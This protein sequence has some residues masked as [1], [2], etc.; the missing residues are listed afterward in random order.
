MAD[1]FQAASYALS[2]E[3]LEAIKGFLEAAVK[4]AHQRLE[5]FKASPPCLVG[6]PLTWQEA[7]VAPM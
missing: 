3:L 1:K 2:S 4:E 6:V 7:F 5:E